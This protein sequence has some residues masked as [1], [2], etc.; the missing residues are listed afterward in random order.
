MDISGVSPEA[1]AMATS[2]QGREIKRQAAVM[3]KAKDVAEV[4]AQSLIQLVKDADVGTR[5]DVYA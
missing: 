4:Q 1:V 3:N 5:L 2:A